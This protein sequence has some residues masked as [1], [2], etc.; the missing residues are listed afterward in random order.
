MIQ[1]KVERYHERLD[2]LTPADMYFGRSQ[3]ILERRARNKRKTLARR[4]KEHRKLAA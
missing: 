1:S 2:N 3:I 4:R